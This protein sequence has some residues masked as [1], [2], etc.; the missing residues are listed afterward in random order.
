VS[1]EQQYLVSA[2]VD[3]RDLGVFDTMKGGDVKIKDAKHRPGG[4]GPE[5]SYRTLPTYDDVTVTRVGELERDWELIR[6]MADNSGA[7][8]ATIT[9]QP[10]DD[11]GNAW[12]TPMTW[13]GRLASV[14]YGDVDS[15]SSSPIMWSFD[16]SVET[17]S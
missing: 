1:T 11:Q 17:R 15:T 13:S 8:T 10:L 7:V 12:G 6:W 4:M 9:R 3:G 5:K 14:T 16:V 2:V